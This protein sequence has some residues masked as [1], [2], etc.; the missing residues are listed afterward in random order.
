MTASWRAKKIKNP[1]YVG[2][3]EAKQIEN[4]EWFEEA[5]PMRK[6]DP[7]GAVTFELWTTTSGITFDDLI[8][9]NSVDEAHAAAEHWRMRR[10][11]EDEND[12]VSPY[13]IFKKAASAVWGKIVALVALFMDPEL[14]EREASPW[15]EQAIEN[16]L[17]GGLMGLVLLSPFI[18]LISVLC[19]RGSSR[20][21]VDL[22]ADDELE[23]DED[24]DEG[25]NEAAGE[26]D[27]S[28]GEKQPDQ[29]T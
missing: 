22:T 17:L 16:P 14:F 2:P 11:Q 10:A 1:E 15:I 29:A 6:L 8:I 25:E 13:A 18:L 21:D 20:D 19:C 3:W 7:I 28:D 26:S 23:E 27:A 4:P 12:A 24:E 5:E 9:T